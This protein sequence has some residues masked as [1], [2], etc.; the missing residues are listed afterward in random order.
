[1]EVPRKQ[2]HVRGCSL[3]CMQIHLALRKQGPNIIWHCEEGEGEEKRPQVWAAVGHCSTR[4]FESL[5]RRLVVPEVGRRRC[6]PR[7]IQIAVGR[8]MATEIAPR[9]RREME[10]RLKGTI[11]W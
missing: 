3:E 4:Q 10:M 2:K 7:L 11:S 9:R 1:M 5:G 8:T 6:H